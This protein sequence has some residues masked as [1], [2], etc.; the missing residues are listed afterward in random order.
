MSAA[1]NLRALRAQPGL[2]TG[3]GA[4]DALEAK[5]IQQ[6]GFDFVWSSGFCISAS[7]GVADAG[8]VS[9]TQLLGRARSMA[10]AIDIPIVADCDTGF[11][12]ANNLLYANHPLRASVLAVERLLAEI[13]S[14]AGIHTVDDQMVPVSR[15]FDLQDVPAMKRDEKKYIP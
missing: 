4:R 7:Y 13:K 5:L 8:L 1:Q 14:A 15:I 11:S 6:A 3:V 10:E 12:N 2:L 9:M